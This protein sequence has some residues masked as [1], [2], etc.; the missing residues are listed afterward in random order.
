M[1]IGKY[2]KKLMPTNDIKDIDYFRRA[3]D[4]GAEEDNQQTERRDILKK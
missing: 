3:E 1:I 2:K 4:S